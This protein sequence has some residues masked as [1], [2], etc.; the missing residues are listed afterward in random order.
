MTNYL[1]NLQLRRGRRTRLRD[2]HADRHARLNELGRE[3]YL[4]DVLTRI[5]DHPI[6]GV[7][8]LLPGNGAAATLAKAA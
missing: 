4:R 6:I 7:S 2:P 8:D 3:A 5:A 1:Y